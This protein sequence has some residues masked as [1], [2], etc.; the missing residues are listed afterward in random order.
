[1]PLRLAYFGEGSGNIWIDDARCSG[2]EPTLLECPAGSPIG[3]SNCG[4]AEDAGVRCPRGV[5]FP[6]HDTVELVYNGHHSLG[7]MLSGR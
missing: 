3:M 4:H 6:P 5:Y 7:T 1:M 2:G